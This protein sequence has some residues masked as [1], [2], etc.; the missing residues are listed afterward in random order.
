MADFHKAFPSKYVA[1]SDLDGQPKN[2]TIERVDWEKV[3]QAGDQR[4]VAYFK[5]ATKGC[6]LNKT[7]CT[8]IAK[9][10]GSTDTDDWVGVQV[11]LYPAEVEFQGET[12]QAIRIRQPQK[13][14]VVA[15]PKPKPE[16]EPEPEGT[17]MDDSEIPF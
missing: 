17:P 16:P 3:G 7:N 2:L 14:R 15:A 12:V 1:A 13:S 11:Q 4:W 9:I 10:A 6:V 5:G 8:A